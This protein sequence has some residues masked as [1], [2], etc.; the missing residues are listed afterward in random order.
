[1]SLWDLRQYVEQSIPWWA[2]LAALGILLA[3]WLLLKLW[4]YIDRRFP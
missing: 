1:M 3:G 4:Y 2:P